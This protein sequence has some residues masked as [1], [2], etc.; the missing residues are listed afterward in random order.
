[1]KTFGKLK[2]CYP[3]IIIL[4]FFSEMPFKGPINSS[5]CILMGHG[6]YV[7]TKWLL[8]NL[9]KSYKKVKQ[10]IT[11]WERDK[12]V[13]E[14]KM[15]RLFSLNWTYKRKRYVY[16]SNWIYKRSINWV[17]A[18]KDCM[19]VNGQKYHRRSS[20][21]AKTSDRHRMGTN[22]SRG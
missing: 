5:L 15:L 13:Q 16:S 11:N 17:I 4:L 22:S 6:K 19:L 20:S 10:I 3:I 14:P 8:T 1:M 7:G 9:T 18:Y 21:L 12:T 2:T